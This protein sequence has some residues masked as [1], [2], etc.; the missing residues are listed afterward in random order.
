[1]ATE[2]FCLKWNEFE[3]N[4]RHSFRCLRKD[5]TLFDVTLATDDGHHVQAHRLILS[6]GS[7]FFGDIFSKCNQTNMLIY[8]KGVSKI[9]IENIAD[10]LYDD[11]A[12]VSQEQLNSFLETAQELKIKGLQNI[13]DD[14]YPNVGHETFAT[15]TDSH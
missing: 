13:E 3:K 7:D 11:E 1:M 2:K 9:D 15:K 5:K 6:A 10:F 8:L 4:I 14:Q 12:L